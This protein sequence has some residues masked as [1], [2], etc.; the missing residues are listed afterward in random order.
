[1]WN[2]IGVDILPWSTFVPDIYLINDLPPVLRRATPSMFGD[3][4]MWIASDS[5]PE[6]LHLLRDE[7]ALLEKWMWDNKLTLNI[8][9][10]EFILISSIPKRRETCCIQIQDESIYRSAYTKSLEFY[11]DQHLD[12]EDDINHVFKKASAGIT[13]LRAPCRYLPLMPH[14]PFTKV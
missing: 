12:W 1:M 2:S 11:I 7:I 4:S 3:A 5:V 8:L 13:I 9:K 14:R 10:T 6:L